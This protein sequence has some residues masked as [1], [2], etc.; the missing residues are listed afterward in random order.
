MSRAARLLELLENLRRRRRPVTG[1]ELAG[2]L[3]VSLRTLYRDIVTLQ[4]QGADIR[5]E[6]GLGYILK[7]GFTLPPL[8]FT[9]DEVEALALGGRFVASRGDP[10]LAQAAH[11]ALA[12][13]AAV[14][15][16]E[17]AE[18]FS[19]PAAIVGPG[20]AFETDD[21]APEIRDAIRR[22]RKLEFAYVDGKS[23]ATQRIV[24]PITLA[25]FDRV[26]VLVAWCETRIAFRHFRLDRMRAPRVL[27]S[28]YPARRARL[29]ADWRSAEG[30]QD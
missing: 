2:E 17:R 9:I 3:G 18:A 13:I 30:I 7:P 28:R 11:S 27:E 16:A 19:A 23:A 5:G 4:G 15:P 10:L 14:V 29:L 6:G 21:A 20:A 8:T 1:A 12:K 25:Y 22:E 24:W 26:R